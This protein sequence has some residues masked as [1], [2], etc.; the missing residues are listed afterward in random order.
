M[1]T[2]HSETLQPE[3]AFHMPWA[4]MELHCTSGHGTIPLAITQS[5]QGKEEAPEQHLQR[6]TW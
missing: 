6:D 4:G 5:V 1:T 2:E 3:H